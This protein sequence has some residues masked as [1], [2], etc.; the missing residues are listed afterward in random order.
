MWR[1]GPSALAIALLAAAC[2][3]QAPVPRE[4][5]WQEAQEAF[6]DGAYELAVQRYKALL[7][8]DPFD[9]RAEEAQLKI[10]YAHYLA[11]RYAEAVAGFGDFE[12]MHPT[13][14]EL[15][16]VEYHLGMSYLSQTST[17][18]RDKEPLSNA[19]NYFRNLVDRFPGSPWAEKA[20][21]RVRE[22]REALA[23]H[24]ADVATFYLRRGNLRAAEARLHGMLGEYP[25]TDAAAQVLYQ[26]AGAYTE[27]QESEGATLA[28]ATLVRYHPDDPLAA[29][30]RARLGLELDALGGADP[31]PLLQARIDQVRERGDR[32]A[33]RPTVSA[34]P[35]TPGAT[36]HR[37]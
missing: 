36:P 27:R 20:R 32:Q 9:P 24:E 35:D 19:L 25:D 31:L 37:Y 16:F 8:E 13:S 30:A 5:L 21:L 2:A 12:R 1:R 29:E 10:A 7:E 28:L 3:K 11:G 4:Q 6:D 17:S 18:D 22:C 23:A 34:Y 14:T 33:A 15:P 26:F